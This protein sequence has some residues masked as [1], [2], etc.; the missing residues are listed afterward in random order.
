MIST[1]GPNFTIL[2]EGYSTMR[3]PLFN[4]SNYLDWRTRMKLFIQANN[5]VWRIITNG[6]FIHMKRVEGVIFPKEESE[7]DNNYIKK[8]QL[9]AKDM[10]T[11]FYALS[12]NEYIR[13]SLCNNAKEIWDK[14]GVTHE[15]TS[16]VK[17]SKISLITLDYE[18]FKKT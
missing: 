14:I 2:G 7:W 5:C 1:F 13:V 11:L 16:R 10:D 3:P 18:L 6:S 4:G 12:A 17:D 15:G 9:N 8:I